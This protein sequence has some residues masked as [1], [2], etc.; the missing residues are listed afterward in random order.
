MHTVGHVHAEFSYRWMIQEEAAE[1]LV[2]SALD[3]LAAPPRLPHG[4]VSAAAR[5]MQREPTSSC[6]EPLPDEF[7]LLVIRMG[8]GNI[9]DQ[10]PACRQPSRDVG[11][12]I[13]HR[14][15]R[16]GIALQQLE[17]TPARVIHIVSSG[18]TR[19]ESADDRMYP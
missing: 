18:R 14:C 10:E 6:F 19:G 16:L 12:I 1:S 15:A 11:E 8:T 5:A 7:V 3:H 2:I 17:Q 9:G 13:G 4:H